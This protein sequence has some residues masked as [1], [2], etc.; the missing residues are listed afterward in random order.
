MVEGS[1]YRLGLPIGGGKPAAA[2]RA[3]VAEDA[4]L[5]LE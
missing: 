2:S 4:R 5:V 3:L 1:T